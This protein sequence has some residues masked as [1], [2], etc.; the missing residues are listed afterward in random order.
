MNAQVIYGLLEYFKKNPKYKD[1]TMRLLKF[2]YD[3]VYRDLSL[4]IEEGEK[5][6][7]DSYVSF[8]RDFQSGIVD[9]ID[10]DNNSILYYLKGMIDDKKEEYI[11]YF[12]DKIESYFTIVDNHLFREADFVYYTCV[13]NI[14]MMCKSYV[15]YKDDFESFK[16]YVDEFSVLI[17]P[18]GLSDDCSCDCEFYLS[19]KKEIIDKIF[20]LDGFEEVPILKERFDKCYKDICDCSSDSE[21]LDTMLE[22][23][24]FIVRV[25]GDMR[26]LVLEDPDFNKENVY[27]FLS[28]WIDYFSE[29]D[30]IFYAPILLYGKRFEYIRDCYE[31]Y[32]SNNVYMDEV[33]E[34]I[35][36]FDNKLFKYLDSVY[37]DGKDS[38]ITCMDIVFDSDSLKEVENKLKFLR[39]VSSM[40]LEEKVDYQTVLEKIKD[41]SS[42]K[43]VK[44]YNGKKVMYRC[45]TL[46]KTE[47]SSQILDRMA[48]VYSQMFEV[49]EDEI[50]YN[51]VDHFSYSDNMNDFEH[52]VDSSL[53][54][55]E[56]KKKEMDS[57]KFDVVEEL[58]DYGLER[59]RE[60]NMGYTFSGESVSDNSSSK[61]GQKS[62]Y[63]RLF[64]MK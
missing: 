4:K 15:K 50:R 48:E 38:F 54:E 40:F 58:S 36:S 60:I 32:L 23:M 42:D 64:G 45:D 24:D 51:V 52:N 13:F 11:D 57:K 49:S 2:L 62:F 55:L 10:E 39:E 26:S 18:K 37:K 8:L 31:D 41:L 9:F 35:L 43:L 28:D 46:N 19:T 20:E 6:D 12:F 27:S 29:D 17:N 59:N 33:V 61:E 30:E 44:V 14:Y 63:K 21:E 7:Y 16:K 5:D 47:R 22:E 3:D 1:K 25:V 34:Y 53:V 56:E